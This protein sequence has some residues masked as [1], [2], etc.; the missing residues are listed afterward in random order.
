MGLVVV[1]LDDEATF[2]AKHGACQSTELD[3]FE[4]N[5]RRRRQLV[6]CAEGRTA[7]SSQLP[8]GAICIRCDEGLA[9]SRAD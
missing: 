3:G 2:V 6:Y 9:S 5:P 8:F 1:K 4:P 7:A